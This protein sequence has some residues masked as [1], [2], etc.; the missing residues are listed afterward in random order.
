MKK[1]NQIIKKLAVILIGATFITSLAHAQQTNPRKL[2]PCPKPDYSKNTDYE[3]YANWTNCWGRYRME[4]D[5]G[6]KGNVLI[7]EWLNGGLN[8]EGTYTSA[9]GDKYVGEFK[10][11]TY[12]GRGAYTFADGEKYVGEWKDGKRNG[13]GTNTWADGA[14]YVGGYVNDMRNGQGTL[15]NMDGSKYVG[16]FKGDKFHGQGTYT[17][18]CL[19][20]TSDAAD[21]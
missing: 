20:Y 9:K 10:D 4:L 11:G 8:G 6:Y 2:P 3:R 21:E 13:Q 15:I 1:L 5:E 19:L 18:T 16:E 12:H 14:E 17:Y 7:G